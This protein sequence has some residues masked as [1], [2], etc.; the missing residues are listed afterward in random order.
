MDNELLHFQGQVGGMLQLLPRL[1]AD[2]MIQTDATENHWYHAISLCY[3]FPFH[4][5]CIAQLYV[6]CL[7]MKLAG[8]EEVRGNFIRVKS[9]VLELG[10]RLFVF[11]CV[12]HPNSW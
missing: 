1:K 11:C 5:K 8:P 4:L 12:P 10:F 2:A 9:C 6:L 7:R 3:C